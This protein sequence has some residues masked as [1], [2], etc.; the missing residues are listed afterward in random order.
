MPVVGGFKKVTLDLWEL[1]GSGASSEANA[2][3]PTLMERQIAAM[4]AVNRLW[5]T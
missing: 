5:F 3:A 2:L 4:V 1:S